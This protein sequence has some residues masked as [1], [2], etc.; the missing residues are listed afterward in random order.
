MKDDAPKLSKEGMK[1]N[2]VEGANETQAFD[3]GQAMGTLEHL[4]LPVNGYGGSCAQ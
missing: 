1:I 2:R 4:Q 3:S